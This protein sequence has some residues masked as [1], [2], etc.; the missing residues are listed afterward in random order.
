MMKRIR[1]QS[2]LVLNI[3]NYVVMNWTAN[4]LLAI[5]ASPL[6]AHARQEMEDMTDLAQSL[7]IN[8][9]TLSAPWVESMEA[10]MTAA[11]HKHKPIVF[12]PVGV[13]ASLYR[14][15]T[16]Q[17]L[18]RKNNPTVIRANA[19]EVLAL[20][21]YKIQTKGVDS[22]QY[23]HQAIEAAL[24]LSKEYDTVVCISGATDYI[25]SQDTVLESHFGHEIMTR[26]TGMGCALSAIVAAYCAVE[27][28]PLE[29]AYE[30][31]RRVGLIGEQAQK[32]S[33]GPGSFQ[34]KFLDLLYNEGAV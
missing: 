12:D 15:Q 26:V 21:G 14:T 11:K 5:G 6:M 28:S 18:I 29:A 10:A 20:A 32:Q 9:G 8:M 7:L 13:G 30:A 1:K 24:R 19:S 25:V 17:H 27:S 22:T 23:S 34:V 4:C 2:P 33:L 31:T 3:T 16:A